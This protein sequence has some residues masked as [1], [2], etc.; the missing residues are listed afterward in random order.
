MSTPMS[1]ADSPG[2]KRSA[3]LQRAPLGSQIASALRRD[4]F[5]GRLRPG[6]RLGQ[7]ELCEEFGTSRMPV[8]DALRELVYD[9]LLMRDGART[10]VVAPLNRADLLDSF[11][12]EGMLNGMAAER[13]TANATEEDFAALESYHNGMQESLAASDHAQMARYNWLFHRYINRLSQ[14]RKLIA[15]LRVVSLDVPRDY[16]TE[17]PEWGRKSNREHAEIIAAMRAG[18]A[19][20]A[21]RL[22]TDHLSNSGAGL[23]DFLAAKGL[24]ID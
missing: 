3:D 4:I 5:L 1:P 18:D 9:G 24:E 16:L 19:E 8:R 11:H 17:V 15:A 12:I 20:K 13:A 7:Q 10:V 21:N 22:M 23:A 14:S 2:T 6:T